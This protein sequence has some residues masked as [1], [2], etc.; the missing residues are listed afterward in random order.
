MS[1]SCDHIVGLC[2]SKPGEGLT[3][4]LHESDIC[5]DATTEFA[6]CPLCG[7]T[8][9]EGSDAEFLTDLAESL[10]NLDGGWTWRELSS[11][12]LME[13]AEWLEGR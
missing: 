2:V 6:F 12:R 4:L 11:K 9:G 8:L 7:A 1:E 3:Y 13:I 5:P 10:R